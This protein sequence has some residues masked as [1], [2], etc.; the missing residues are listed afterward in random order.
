MVMV[1]VPSAPSGIG[2]MGIGAG[3][4]IGSGAGSGIARSPR[5]AIPPIPI[6][7]GS[8]CRCGGR[9]IVGLYTG[10]PGGAWAAASRS[11]PYMSM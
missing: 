6:G 2:E 9:R 11:S 7:A 10:W 3:T 4:G 5:G 1:T 8:V